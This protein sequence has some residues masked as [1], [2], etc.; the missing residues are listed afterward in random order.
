MTTTTELKNIILAIKVA[1]ISSRASIVL[2]IKTYNHIKV[3]KM[4]K[5]YGF[6]NSFEIRGK[7]LVVGLQQAYS[8]NA[9]KGF[10]SFITVQNLHRI[11]RKNTI[12]ARKISKVERELGNFQTSFF[13]TDQG[14]ITG[15]GAANRCVGGFPLFRIK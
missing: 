4:L 1:T 8:H 15:Q 12:I 7:Y 10:P 14:I 6:I 11:S 13:S 2:P 3:L 5:L 9:G